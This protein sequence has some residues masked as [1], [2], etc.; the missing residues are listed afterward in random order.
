M[1]R[2]ETIEQAKLIRSRDQFGKLTPEETAKYAGNEKELYI[3]LTS[4]HTV[5]VFEVR[6]GKPLSGKAPIIINF[7][8]GGFIKGRTARDLRYCSYLAEK[9]NCLVWDVDYSLAPEEPFPYAADECFGII[10]YAFANAEQLGVD[11]S[12]IALAGHSSGGNLAASA[13]IKA[14]EK[15]EFHPCALLLEYFPAD[16]SRDPMERLTSE[17][18]ADERAVARAMTERLYNSFYCTSEQQT[19]PL[20]SPIYAPL[21]AL[22]AFPDCLVISAQI[23]SLC[24]ETEAFAKKLI[25]AGVCVTSRRFLNSMHGFT[26]NHTDEWEEA[27]ELHYRFFREYLY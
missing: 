9:L 26:T 24:Q 21:E 8:G 22:S 10:E 16:L 23:D 19:N 14:A 13:C 3:N 17:Q 12:R 5:H 1:T 7:H 6:S 15:N 2:E 25:G 20:A 27:L 4:G 11:V 18:M